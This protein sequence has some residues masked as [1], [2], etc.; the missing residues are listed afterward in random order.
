MGRFFNKYELVLIVIIF[1]LLDLNGSCKEFLNY[2][3]YKNKNTNSHTIAFIIILIALLYDAYLIHV[4][5][6]M[7]PDPDPN[8]QYATN[9]NIKTHN[10]QKNYKSESDYPE[11]DA[12]QSVLTMSKQIVWSFIAVVMLIIVLVC[13]SRNHL[14]YE[15]DELND[16]QIRFVRSVPLILVAGILLYSAHKNT[17]SLS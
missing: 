17:F 14:N 1:V 4:I 6:E 2:I 10:E 16:L 3:L 15:M 7:D 13:L 9:N 11:S 12:D 5:V 8:I